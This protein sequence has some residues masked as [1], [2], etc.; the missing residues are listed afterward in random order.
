[1]RFSLRMQE[2][3]FCLTRVLGGDGEVS[4]CEKKISVGFIIAITFC[5]KYVSITLLASLYNGFL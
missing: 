4:L 1:M 2:L 3:F 5:Y